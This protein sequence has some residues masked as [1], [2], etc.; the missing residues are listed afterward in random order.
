MRR[1]RHEKGAMRR[2]AMGRGGCG[3]GLLNLS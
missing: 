3:E 2:G 1:E